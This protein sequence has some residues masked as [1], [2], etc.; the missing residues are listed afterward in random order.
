MANPRPTAAEDLRGEL[1]KVEDDLLKLERER[2]LEGLK[3]PHERP[4]MKRRRARLLTQLRAIAQ[5]RV[6]RET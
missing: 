4:I 3:K 5:A 1:R 2:A 6:I